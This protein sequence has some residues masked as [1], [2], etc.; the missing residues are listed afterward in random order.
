VL[1]AG[2][3]ADAG[4]REVERRAD[5]AAG[6]RPSRAK[7]LAPPPPPSRAFAPRTPT[8][9]RT[10]HGY[11]FVGYGNVGGIDMPCNNSD[12]LVFPGGLGEMCQP[13]NVS[14][15]DCRR[16]CNHLR[17]CAGFVWMHVPKYSPYRECYYKAE[18]HLAARFRP[19]PNRAKGISVIW[20][21]NGAAACE[22]G[23]KSRTWV[24]RYGADAFEMRTIY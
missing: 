11:T 1:S 6:T 13:G 23:W 7:R 20:Q 24:D 5:Y 2:A 22:S 15:D 9:N 8:P 3:G 12:A 19:L 14:V 4:L 21:R 10:A 18:C 17:L 16:G